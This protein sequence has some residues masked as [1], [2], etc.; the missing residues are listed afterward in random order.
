LRSDRRSSL[1]QL[2]VPVKN[3]FRFGAGHHRPKQAVPQQAALQL[4]RGSKKLAALLL[5]NKI[6]STCTREKFASRSRR[7]YIQNQSPRR[8]CMEGQ[9]HSL[10]VRELRQPTR[11]EF[12]PK[13]PHN[14]YF[15]WK[16]NI[17]R[18]TTRTQ[19]YQEA[20]K[21]L[22]ATHWKMY[23]GTTTS[24]LGFINLSPGR[25]IFTS[26]TPCAVTTSLPVSSALLQLRSAP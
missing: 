12:S 25:L 2:C 24:A 4:T 23:V 14:H 3:R 1:N 21:S 6:L 9:Y 11:F 15:I 5:N 20:T 19:C 16:V 10:L 26:T 13:K 8:S 22:L 17:L 7:S 18:I